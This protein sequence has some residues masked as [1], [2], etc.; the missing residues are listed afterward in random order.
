MTK[1]SERFVEDI[2]DRIKDGQI[3]FITLAKELMI[4][5]SSIAR[6]KQYGN[7]LLEKHDG[8]REKTLN[9]IYANFKPGDRN[10]A[11]GCVRFTTDIPAASA[12]WIGKMEK[13]VVTEG[14]V[15]PT[16]ALKILERQAPKQWAKR[17]HI[18][19]VVETKQITTII[20]HVQEPRQ[21]EESY[22]INAEFEEV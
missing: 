8:D 7:Q 6:W 20:E 3:S 21:L 13:V 11:L 18:D 9:D 19:S 5:Q 15:N 4:S 12:V 14:L 22:P 1:I 10:Y 17:V 2:V 16:M